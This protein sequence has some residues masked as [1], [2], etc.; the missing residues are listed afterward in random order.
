MT[1]SKSDRQYSNRERLPKV[2]QDEILRREADFESG[3]I[4]AESWE[5]VRKRFVK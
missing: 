4:K 2:Q 1:A 3:K 5:K